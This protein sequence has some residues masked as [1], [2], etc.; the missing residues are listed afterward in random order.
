VVQDQQ[1]EQDIGEEEGQAGEEE[2]GV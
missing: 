1:V 2:D